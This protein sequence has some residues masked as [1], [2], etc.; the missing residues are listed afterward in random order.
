LDEGVY[1]HELRDELVAVGCE[2]LVGTLARGLA[3]L[4]DPEPQRGDPTTAEKISHED[5][6]LDWAAAAAQLHRVVRLERAWTT[7]RGRRFGVRKAHPEVA[8][9]AGGPPGTLVGTTVTTGQGTL[10]LDLVQPESRRPMPAEE[11]ARGARL[12]VGERLGSD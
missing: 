7:F 1:L 12:L 5:L 11:W 6:R 8:G 2:L 3:G 4:P 9:T 10:Q